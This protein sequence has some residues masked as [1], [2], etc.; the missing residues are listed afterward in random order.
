MILIEPPPSLKE[1]LNRF[2]FEPADSVTLAN[3][4]QGL[5]EFYPDEHL[6]LSVGYDYYGHLDVRFAFET[7]EDAVV[8]KLKWAV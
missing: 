8:F 1:Y 5:R 2:L 7:E 4:R 6:E 3:I